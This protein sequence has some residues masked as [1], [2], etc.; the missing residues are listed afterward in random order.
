MRIFT[1]VAILIML[2][3]TAMAKHI[4][5]E[6]AKSVAATFWE[7]NVQK[8]SGH[9]SGIEFHDITA[10]TEFSN[11]YILNTNGGFVIVS[12]DD[13][14]KPILGYSRQGEFNIENIPINAKDWLRSYCNEIQYA[15]DNNI[16]AGEETREAWNKLRNG[17]GLTPKSTRS[18]S[19]LLTTT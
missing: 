2:S 16:E 6:T 11:I 4:D 10:Q 13:A 18:V 9:K 7:N 3:L 12:S 8:G 14:A 17:I 15:I 1:F 5:L 19:Q